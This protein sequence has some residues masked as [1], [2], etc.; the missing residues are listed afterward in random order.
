MAKMTMAEFPPTACALCP[1][2]LLDQSCYVD[3]VA[4][5]QLCHY[6][7]L[8]RTQHGPRLQTLSLTL[9]TSSAL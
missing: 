5:S 4:A 8:H 6:S 9:S 3:S 1:P 7:L 2:C